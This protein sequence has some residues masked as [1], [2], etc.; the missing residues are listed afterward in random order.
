M[1]NIKDDVL[2]GLVYIYMILYKYSI[3]HKFHSKYYLCK[4]YLEEG[5]YDKIEYLYKIMYI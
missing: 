5:T 3:C 1:F 2:K 4:N